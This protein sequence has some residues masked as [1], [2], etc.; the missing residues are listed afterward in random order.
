MKA[1]KS[2]ALI[3]GLLF[4]IQSF[5]QGACIPKDEKVAPVVADRTT[6]G[7]DGAPVDTQ[8]WIDWKTAV[9]SQAEVNARQGLVCCTGLEMNA[10][11]RICHDNSMTDTTL[12]KCTTQADCSGMPGNLG[13]FDLRDDDMFKL[14][15]NSTEAQVDAVTSQQDAFENQSES[16]EPKEKGQICTRN[17]DCESYNCK[18]SSGLFPTCQDPEKICRLAALNETALGSVKC[19]EP[20]QKDAMLKCIDPTLSVYR[21]VLGQIIPAATDQAKC[22]FEL[23]PTAP[24]ATPADIRP[25]IDLAIG[26]TRSLEWLFSTSSHNSDCVRVNKYLKEKIKEKLQSRKEILKIYSL[27]TKQVEDNFALV[28]SAQKDNMEPILTLCDDTTTQHD[29]A[30][31]RATGL[32]F[33]CYMKKRNEVFSIYEN[34]MLKWTTEV[35]DLIETYRN[36]VFNYDEGAKSWKIGD[37]NYSWRDRPA[38][39]Y[40][41]DLPFGIKITPKKLKK[42][43]EQKYIVSP[44][45]KFDAVLKRENVSNYMS[46]MGIQ[47]SLQTMRRGYYL[48]PIMPGEGNNGVNFKSFGGGAGMLTSGDHQ[49]TLRSGQMADMYN[50]YNANLTAFLKQMKLEGVAEEDFIYE[51]EIPSSYD[52]RGCINK[53]D[54][55][56]CAPFKA[57]VTK[58]QDI[59]FAQFLAYSKHTKSKYKDFYKSPNTA[60]QKLWNRYTTDLTNMENYYSALDQLRKAQNSCIDKVIS[61]IRGGGFSGEGMG[62]TQGDGNYYVGSETNYQNTPTPATT[63]APVIK[64][65]QALTPIKL[66]L[67]VYNKA[68]KTNTNNGSTT[69]GAGAGS[70]SVDSSAG[71]LAARN[72]KIADANTKATSS[73]Y[74]LKKEDDEIRASMN[75][76]RSSGAGAGA[77]GAASNSSNSASSFGAGGN[78]ATLDNESDANKSSGAS[79][80]GAASASAGGSAVPAAVGAIPGLIGGAASGAAAS[81]ALGHQ[82]ATG[83]SDEEKDVMAANY[84]RTKT[85]YQTN[86]DDSLFQVVSKTYVRNLDKILTRKKKLDDSSSSA[87]SQ[88]STP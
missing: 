40:W 55:P 58:I 1:L 43:W 18:R 12:T 32:D 4:S 64:T 63:K 67:G 24:G 13:C 68:L 26:T 73:G 16:V 14:D 79:A 75:S 69:S 28:T 5:A 37:R 71:S 22:Q 7:P 3:I 74:D 15:D 9:G 38:C 48:D 33:L 88:P 27:N 45:P 25:A 23:R 77:S 60:R 54:T 2:I 87:P 34:D 49:R 61:Q 53:I 31:R 17:M 36:D 50:K 82:D 19:E 85:R 52:Y 47:N 39:R 29:V 41:I 62:V 59:S 44:N 10:T 6:P 86:E 20:Y 51:P 11:T 84:D 57:Y 42:R 70:G 56:Q 21:G 35:N 8:V 81:S 46:Y 30:M 76:G 66:T 83:M 65:G 72:K 80:T 78:K